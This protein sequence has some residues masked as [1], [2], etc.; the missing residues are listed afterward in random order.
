MLQYVIT[1]CHLSDVLVCHHICGDRWNRCQE[2][3]NSCPFGVLTGGDHQDGLVLRGWRLSSRTWNPI[4][5]TWMK[6]LMWL[7]I[8]HSGDWCLRLALYTPSGACHERRIVV[9]YDKF[10]N[11][12]RSVISC[13]V[14]SVS[15]SVDGTVY[16]VLYVGRWSVAQHC[17]SWMNNSNR[18]LINVVSCPVLTRAIHCQT[19]CNGHWT[20]SPRY[21]GMFINT[22]ASVTGFVFVPLSLSCQVRCVRI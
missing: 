6:Q 20:P 11:V 21:E 9:A 7:R 2:D 22:V 5:S 3:L 13:D 8:V 14:S 10:D 12:A 1:L 19:A 15:Y 16:V 18:Q 4:T 17:C